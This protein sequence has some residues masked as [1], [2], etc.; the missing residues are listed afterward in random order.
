MK[1]NLPKQ[2]LPLRSL[3]IIRHSLNLFTDT[4]PN[5]HGSTPIDVVVVMDERYRGEYGGG[6]IFADPGE[7]RQGSV[8]NGMKGE[9]E[10]THG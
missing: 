9:F 1:A 8:E 2:F 5:E 4:L 6:W 7:E 3:P 10:A